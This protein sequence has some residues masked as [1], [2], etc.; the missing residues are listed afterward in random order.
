[1]KKIISLVLA[2]LM[3]LPCLSVFASERDVTEVQHYGNIQEFINDSLE[4][5]NKA[6]EIQ[7]VPVA[8]NGGIVDEED[9]STYSEFETCRLIVESEEKPDSLNSVGIASGFMDYHIVQFTN[10]YDTKTAFEYYSN[11][12]DVVSVYPDEVVTLSDD[13]T[14]EITVSEQT[15]VPERLNSWGADS[16]GF[17]D[18]KDYLI[19]NDIPMEEVVVGVVDTGIDLEHEFFKGRLIETGFNVTNSGEKNSE[20]DVEHGHGT[21]VASVIVDST[22]EK[23]KVASYKVIENDGSGTATRVSL[24]ILQ[25]VEDKVDIINASLGLENSLVADAVEYA[26]EEKIPV[27]AA[28]AND[29]G[30]IDILDVYPAKCK[31]AITVAAIDEFYMPVDFTNYGREVDVSAPG[32]KIHVADIGNAYVYSQGTSFSAPYTAAVCAIY[33]SLNNDCSVDENEEIIKEKASSHSALLTMHDKI[34]EWYGIG[35]ID[36]VGVSGFERQAEVKVNVEPGDYFKTISIEL[37]SEGADEIY[38]TLD[39][40]IPTKENG[41]LYTGPIEI[42]SDG[43][44]VKAI[45][46]SDGRLR[47]EIFSGFYKSWIEEPEE[48]FTIN[49]NGK[50]LSYTGD[51]HYV[52]IPET[53]N[54]ITVTD[55]GVQTFN[56]SEITGIVLPKTVTVLSTNAFSNNETIKYVYGEAITEIGTYA[57]GGS[58]VLY[59]D[60]PNAEKVNEAAFK[61]TK[62]MFGINLPELKFADKEAFCNNKML[63]IYLPELETAGLSC[64]K[65]SHNLIEIYIPK[66][67]TAWNLPVKKNSYWFQDSYTFKA[68]DLPSVGAIYENDFISLDEK[69]IERIEFSNLRKFGGVPSSKSMPSYK[70]VL[71]ATIEEITV[72][73]KQFTNGSYTFYGTAGTMAEQWIKELDRASIRFVE[74]TPENAIVTDLPE[75]YKS[76]MGELEPDIMGFNRTYQWYANTVDSNEGG[77]PIEG[78]TNKKFN[79]AVYPAPYYYC[80]VTS[81]DKGYEPM[82]IKTSVCENRSLKTIDYSELEHALAKV[83][84]DLSIY[85]AESKDVLEKIIEETKDID[86]LNQKQIN[87]LAEKLAAAISELRLRTDIVAILTDYNGVVVAEKVVQG[88][89]TEIVFDGIDDG[90]YTV[91]LSNESYVTREYTVTATDGKASTEFK[92]HRIGDLNGDGK[93]NTMDV[94]RA[95]ASAKGMNALT[96]YELA[97]ADI[98]GDGKVNTMDVARMNAHAKGVS[99]LW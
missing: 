72:T 82:I 84:E 93:V 53:I 70:L 1:M 11:Q 46:Y 41:I 66:L 94:A 58:E 61:N 32:K 89:A 9:I 35:I 57:F 97:C 79:P 15:E 51:S 50:I 30:N 2:L 39:Q 71:P 67:K 19:A 65:S 43:V 92:L 5:I 21:K 7:D 98:N 13:E 47:S 18:V 37:S 8:N 44:V 64:F 3:V 16:T 52:L 24:G 96:G 56:K 78:A 86:G 48:K 17:Y 69:Y 80:E 95:N 73:S 77:T 14:E 33:K 36:V 91:I 99:S 83:P 75:Y 87:E 68:L 38:Y 4:L 28:A 74:L 31:H 10:P 54:G 26:Y 22:P 29:S 59:V 62:N 90:Q 55:I 20:K 6:P 49:D 23:I 12:Q 40:T 85:T 88:D 42:S 76:Y 81:T 25:A 27:V 45:A 60:F 34:D 63:Y